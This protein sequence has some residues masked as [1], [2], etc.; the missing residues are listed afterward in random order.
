MEDKEHIADE[1]KATDA[2]LLQSYG[3]FP[4]KTSRMRHMSW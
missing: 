4:I 2:T 3:E 1:T